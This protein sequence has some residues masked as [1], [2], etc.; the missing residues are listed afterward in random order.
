MRRIIPVISLAI[1]LGGC[2]A[3]PPELVNSQYNPITKARLAAADQSFS[4]AQRILLKYRALR[5]C[6][7]SE[8]T[9]FT[10]LCRKYSI[11]MKLK[12]LEGRV[13]SAFRVADKCVKD[14]STTADCVLGLEAAVG[15]FSLAAISTGVKP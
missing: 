4:D 3:G 9:T 12:D 8:T 1:S 2:P 10:N 15:E 14:Q 13:N 11:Y 7:S 6:K 5:P